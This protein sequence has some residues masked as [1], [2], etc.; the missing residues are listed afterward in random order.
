MVQRFIRCVCILAGILA[1]GLTPIVAEEAPFY[2][3]YMHIEMELR[4]NGDLRITEEQKYVFTG[5][6]TTARYRAIALD[7][8]DEIT[9]A[10]VSHDG[11]VLAA[12]TTRKRNTFWIRWSHPLTPP[13]SHTF[14]LRYIVKGGLRVYDHT[15]M[16]EW[17]ALFP[18]RDAPIQRGRVRL[19]FPAALSGHLQD[20]ASWGVPADV[21][22]LGPTTVEFTPRAPLPPAD[23]YVMMAIGGI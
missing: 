10:S 11:T 21:H 7:K 14:T 12:S 17:S 15:D 22:R 3:E 19:K 18:D 2:W 16:V 23:A 5:P 1:G 9:N 4:D 20:V 13:E 8:V 6:H